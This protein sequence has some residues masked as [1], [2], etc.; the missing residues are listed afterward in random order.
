[1]NDKHAVISNL[2]G[3]CVVM[4]WAPSAITPGATELAYQS[5][6]SFRE[7]YANRY[8]DLPDGRGRTESRPA[9]P[10]W[11]THPQRRQY[12]GLDLVP[13]G[14]PVSPGGYL[15]LWREWGVEP[16][17]GGWQL[18]ER[19]IAEVL[20]NGDQKFEDFI[21]RLTAWKFQNPTIC[22]RWT[23]MAGVQARMFRRRGP[24]SNRKCLA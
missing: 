13:N 7:R 20:A 8:I 18:M 24:W 6:T 16:R 19:H 14:P 3:K 21:R 5:F 1:M 15:N 22:F 23:L 17:K 11:L 2:G 9:A 12:E 10:Y 4:E